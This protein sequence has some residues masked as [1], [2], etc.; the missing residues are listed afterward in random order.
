MSTSKTT[1][2]Q[3]VTRIASHEHEQNATDKT[4]GGKNHRHEEHDTTTAACRIHMVGVVSKQGYRRSNL[5]TA[6]AAIQVN[7]QLLF[8]I[9]IQPELR[10]TIGVAI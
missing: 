9:D 10:L 4:Y 3:M 8:R 7:G 1:A 6:R 5:D 2:M